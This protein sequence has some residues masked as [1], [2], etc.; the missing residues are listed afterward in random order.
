VLLLVLLLPLSWPR[1]GGEGGSSIGPSFTFSSLILS[2]DS[3]AC[4]AA[5]LTLDLPP[6]QLSMLLRLLGTDGGRSS[7]STPYVESS[8][9]L[10]S[11]EMVLERDDMV[12]ARDRILVRPNVALQHTI[13]I[14]TVYA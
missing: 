10:E 14:V 13:G 6:L 3:I 4:D 8:L 11:S 5:E 1:F 7:L 9:M 12:Y 2:R